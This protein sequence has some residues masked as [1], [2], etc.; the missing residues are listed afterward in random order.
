MTDKPLETNAVRI[1]IYQRDKNADYQV[2]KLIS[3]NDFRLR[4]DQIYYYDDYIV[5]H[6]SGYYYMA[7]FALNGLDRPLATADFKVD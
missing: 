1:K 7:I 2:N 5:I 4:K 3:S 6:E